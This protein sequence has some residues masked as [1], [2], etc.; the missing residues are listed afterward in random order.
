MEG[1]CRVIKTSY[2]GPL[3]NLLIAER[4]AQR[5]RWRQHPM[6]GWPADTNKELPV[7]DREVDLRAGRLVVVG[8]GQLFTVL[9]HAGLDWRPYAFGGQHF[10]SVFLLDEHDRLTE[11]VDE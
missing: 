11:L 6:P 10:R 7:T 3:R 4:D 2:S 5:K 8:S 1:W 9:H